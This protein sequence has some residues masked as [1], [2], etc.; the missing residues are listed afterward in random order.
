MIQRY[1]AEFFS[2]QS[3]SNHGVQPGQIGGP[4]WYN[5]IISNISQQI[6]HS[7]FIWFI[8]YYYESNS[9]LTDHHWSGYN[10]VP[11]QKSGPECIIAIYFI[12]KAFFSKKSV[13]MIQRYK[14]EFFLIQYWSNHG[15][16]PDQISGP[17]W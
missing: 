13:E 2:I 7:N 10:P 5:A 16:Q 4:D 14:T 1:K 9:L 6:F 17:D 11:G 12:Y 15:V 3:W 8:K